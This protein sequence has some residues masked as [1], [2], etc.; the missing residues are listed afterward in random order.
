MLYFGTYKR[1]AGV[2][3]QRRKSIFTAQLYI[4]RT[5]DLLFGAF[6]FEGHK[7]A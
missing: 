7:T 2:Y 6:T 4:L 3:Q 5:K 1:K